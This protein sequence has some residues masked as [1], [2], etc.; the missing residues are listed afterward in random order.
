MINNLRTAVDTALD[1]LNEIFTIQ[2]ELITHYNV[3]NDLSSS[4]LLEQSINKEAI[5]TG[6]KLRLID[7]TIN[8]YLSA[9]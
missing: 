5:R 3:T 9:E 4:D 8:K 2:D 6:L 7:H 1:Q